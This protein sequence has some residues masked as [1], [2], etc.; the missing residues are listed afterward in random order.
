MRFLVKLMN[1]ILRKN[2]KV[3]RINCSLEIVVVR[4]IVLF[5]SEQ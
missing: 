2:I 1:D 3:S 5:G 4:T